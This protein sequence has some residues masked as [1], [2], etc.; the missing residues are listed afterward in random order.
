MKTFSFLLPRHLLLLAAALFLTASLGGCA[1]AGGK[2]VRSTET[3]HLFSSG[4]VLAEYRYYYSG[5][6]DEP[7]AILGVHRDY[8]L[9]SELWNRINLTEGQLAKWLDT[10]NSKWMANF[11]HTY[12]G[13]DVVDEAG[14]KIGIWYGRSSWTTVKRGS[15][16]DVYIYTPD[17]FEQSNLGFNS[18]EY[19]N[20]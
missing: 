1:A 18:R 7:D 2:L 6:Q 5:P 9:R 16:N 13:A 12:T 10:M 3:A 20:Y 11:H 8:A 17:P 19:G 4:Q 14:T 15:G